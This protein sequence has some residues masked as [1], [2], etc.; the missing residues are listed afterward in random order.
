[1]STTNRFRRWFIRLTKINNVRVKDANGNNAL[2]DDG[3]EIFTTYE[4]DF[5]EIYNKLNLK[6]DTVLMCIHDKDQNNI[7]AHLCIQ[8]KHQIEFTALKEL[9]PYGDIERQ[10]GTNQDVYEYLLH[11]DEKSKAE[12]K[13][14]YDDKDIVLNV[15]N[16]EKW[17]K[18]KQGQGGQ[19]VDCIDA[20]NNGATYDELLAEYP[21]IVA[22]KQS[23][24]KEQFERK[25][26]KDFGL[27]DRDIKVIYIYGEA[28]TGKTSSVIKE[29]GYANI[30]SVD[31]Y[32]APFDLYDGQDVLLFDE[33]R[34]NF[35]ITYFLKLLDRYPLR[36][37]A[38]YG[39][40]TACYTRV[41]I[42]SNIPLS[43]QYPNEDDM[44]K[45]ALYRRISEIRHY[46]GMGKYINETIP[47]SRVPEDGELVKMDIDGNLP[48]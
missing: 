35:E 23:F 22:T 37:R 16:L 25:R 17:L 48:F 29:H 10:R 44:T 32:R 34:H 7:H 6:Y 43:Q 40:K 14:S 36:L 19:I 30:C 2:D 41:Y 18:T 45:R 3:K 24:I 38:R 27:R 31:N 21:V 15:D 28:G 20:I 9:M 46:T 33:Y 1:M 13:E 8:H 11:R 42:I 5:S 47:S 4:Y 12:G 26:Y 39:D